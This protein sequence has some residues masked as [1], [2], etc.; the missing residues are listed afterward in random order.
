MPVTRCLR[1]VLFAG[2]ALLGLQSVA[3]AQFPDPSVPLHLVVGFPAGG[4]ADV[5]ARDIAPDVAKALG[6]HVIIDNRPGASGVIATDYVARSK[7][8][9]NTVYLATPGSMTILPLLQKVPYD[10]AKSITPIAMLVTMPNVLAVQAGSPIKSVKDLITMA[11]A[12]KDI[13]YASGGEGTIGQMMAE[14]FNMMAGIK[15][16]Q[17]PYKGTAPA[18]TDVASGQVSLI[19]SDPSVKGLIDGG[20]LAAL[21]VTSGKPSAQFPGVPTVADSGLPGYALVNWYGVVGPAHMPASVV[22]KLNQAFAV[23]MRDPKVVAQLA[24]TAGMDATTS[25]PA[26]FTA[27]MATERERWKKLIAVAHIQ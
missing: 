12:G 6:V 1:T 5:L 17:I 3:H 8:D 24:Q 25:T 21:A 20:K 22:E 26:E 18:L 7:P 13:T 19:F 15:M 23:A 9:G 16:R 11:R 4:G 2:A 27:W 14:E 10:P